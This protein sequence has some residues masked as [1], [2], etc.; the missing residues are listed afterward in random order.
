MPL[1]L[2]EIGNDGDYCSS[3]IYHSFYSFGTKVGQR[4]GFGTF[5]TLSRLATSSGAAKLVSPGYGAQVSWWG[6]QLI[7]AE[8]MQTVVLGSAQVAPFHQT[9]SNA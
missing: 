9:N 6:N 4:C 8:F 7:R 1:A 3:R 2:L 5:G